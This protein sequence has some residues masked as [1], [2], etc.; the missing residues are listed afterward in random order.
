M[1]YN[2]ADSS[3]EPTAQHVTEVEK[4]YELPDDALLVPLARR[5]EE[6]DAGMGRGVRKEG[7]NEGRGGNVYGFEAGE[8]RVG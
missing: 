7:A 4:E 8:G 5:E 1:T 3:P 2:G 6:G